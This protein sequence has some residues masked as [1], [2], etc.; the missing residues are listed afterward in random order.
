MSAPIAS[1]LPIVNQALE[2]KWVRDGSP[3][4]QKA[5]ESALAF[6]DTLVEQLSQSLTAA[7]GLTGE[8]SG[9]GESE[10]GGS[11]AGA[12]GNSELA[13][14]LPQGLTSSVMSAGGLGLAAQMTRELESTHAG[15]S[16]QANGGTHAPAG[17]GT[18]AQ[19]NGA[20]QAQANGGTSA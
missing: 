7:S 9:S 1:G 4:T 13:S 2:P 8:S 19:A 16:T 6:E 5:Y 15:T 18:S 3:A 17:D 11:G 20:R 12:S 14:L 10:E